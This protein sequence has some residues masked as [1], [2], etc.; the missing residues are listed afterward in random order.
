MSTT[1]LSPTSYVVLGLVERAGPATPYEIK[2]V[3][4]I[5]TANFWSIPHTQLYTEC[6]RMAEAGLLDE[7]REEGGRRRRTYTLTEVGR[8]VLE[9]W[10]AE[11]AEELYELRDIGIL[12]LF[13]GASPEKLASGQI[14]LHEA[15]LA[16]YEE[17][18]KL[19]MEDGMRRALELGIGI[20]REFLGFWK[21]QLGSD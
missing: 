18:A 15:K 16:E 4:E 13:L 10:R 11:P 12:K 14:E 2:Q 9:E 6:S 20:E 8:S 21:R 1:R 19:P 17:T 7:E 5:S 3:A